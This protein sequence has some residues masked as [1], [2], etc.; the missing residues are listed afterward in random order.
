MTEPPRDGDDGAIEGRA[1]TLG[2][3]RK[4]GDGPLRA[5]ADGDI[6]GRAITLGELGRETMLGWLGRNE[7][8]EENDG[9]DGRKLGDAGWLGL[10][11]CEGMTTRG[12]VGAEDEKLGDE[13]RAPTP[14]LA[15][16]NTGLPALGTMLREAG[17]RGLIDAVR[18]GARAPE[19][20]AVEGVAS[21]RARSMPA[22]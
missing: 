4:L 15:G 14:G 16:R 17:A 13:G 21:V 20:T 1:V 6:E 9:E 2:L 10:M 22:F 19:A 5:G 3:E 12:C 11:R 18:S 8:L 7:G